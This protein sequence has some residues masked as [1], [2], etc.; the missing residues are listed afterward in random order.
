[1]TPPKFLL[2]RTRYHW[3]QFIT[4]VLGVILATTFMA[5]AP[6]LVDAVIELGLRR[7]LSDAGT[8]AGSLYLTTRQT[9]ESEQH[10]ALEE[11]LRLRLQTI[12]GSRITQ[13]IPSGRVGLMYPWRDGKLANARRIKLAFHGSSRDEIDQSANLI[14]GTWPSDTKPS[15]ESI[16]VVVGPSLAN[17]FDL[18]VGE[19][20]PISLNPRVAEPELWLEVRGIAVS[21]GPPDPYWFDTLTPVQQT[22][23]ESG[24]VNYDVFVTQDA[25]FQLVPELYP[26]LRAEYAWQLLLDLPNSKEISFWQATLA[27][28]EQDLVPVNNDLQ[29]NTA[30]DEL[31]DDF[32]AQAAA[33]R[34]PLYFLLATV[35]LIS[36][37]YLVMVSALS[38]DRGRRE[39][40]VMRS[41][42][43]SGGQLFRLQLLEATLVSGIALISGPFLAR[44]FVTALAASGPLADLSGY[45]WTLALSQAAWL[46]AIVA[47]LA[48]VSSLLLPLPASLKRSIVTHHQTMSRPN[49]PPWWQR[50]YLDVFVLVVG[51][52]LLWR[53]QLYGSII[54]GAAEMPRVD[55]L[56]L[57]A[58]LSLLIGAA[59]L[60]L[61]VFPVLLQ[62]G[63]QLASRGRGL[64]APLALWQAARDP[65]HFTRLVLLLM[66][67]MTLG[68]FSTSLDAAL[69]QNERDR[70]RYFV[71][72]DARIVAVGVDESV[73]DQADLTGTTA[74]TWRTSASLDY[75][76][77]FPDL[78]L[79]AI[80]PQSFNEVATYRPD[81]ADRP[82]D[83]LI[84]E[85]ER[86]WRENQGIRL[87]APLPGNLERIGLWLSLPST[88]RQD[89]DRSVL[90]NDITIEARLGPYFGE[91][92]M[93]PLRFKD[94]VIDPGG[95]WH[96][97]E[98]DI[99]SLSQESYPLY[100]HALWV[101]SAT[102]NPAMRENL[103][104]DDIAVIDETGGGGVTIIEDFEDA[105]HAFWYS[106]TA[107][108]SAAPVPSSPRSGSHS[109]VLS[110]GRLGMSPVRSYGINRVIH[111]P[112]LPIPALVS[113]AFQARTELQPGS[114]FQ[115]SVQVSGAS[116]WVKLNFRIVDEVA[117]F[118]TMFD[119]E[120]AGYLVTLIDPLLQQINLNRYDPIRGNE[121]LIATDAMATESSLS[122]ALE[123]PA[124]SRVL[125]AD[126]L[127]RSLKSHPLA[128]GLRSATL[129]GSL[130]TTVLSL[131]GF[132]S[133]FYMTARQRATNYGILRAIGLS[134]RQLYIALMLEQLVLILS[135]LALG[136]VLGL[137][138]NEL[139]LSGLP[140]AL[141]EG[142]IA[143]PF[144]PQ[145]DWSAV[146][147]VYLTLG[148][149]FFLSL[150][151][152]TVFL[153]RLQIHHVLR[154]GE[155]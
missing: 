41:R 43:A 92:K 1:V 115:A 36:L 101:R 15:Q 114:R 146:L 22:Q 26:S 108:M 150:G 65:R 34:S 136:T 99:P 87:A 21:E 64:S 86:F 10:Q 12:L 11:Q 121:L 100:L 48:S 31:F 135:G 35:V 149:T 85:M 25:F 27:T 18:E 38:L 62:A 131:V 94:G 33:V 23:Q 93:V 98:A 72:S 97:F 53:L 68:L 143:P 73:T 126:A 89:P 17:D 57:L 119:T 137:L 14:A 155:E 71:G 138:L 147:R 144:I 20:L 140:L 153:W 151:L 9:P 61:R 112:H 42:G 118:P 105:G 152:A 37:Y 80:D 154:V 70:S 117:F 32:A 139:T 63:A 104:I 134:S 74:V 44:I 7:T 30:L 142:E 67:A 79:L 102:F 60:L 3:Q 133:H 145:T 128:L 103:W 28:L 40:A 148:L 52:I 123:L 39:F 4:L 90:L 141:G 96:Y 59:A 77:T 76:T 78:S 13:V 8:A 75:G 54:G 106:V 127:Y 116:D 81:F 107:P 83:D 109:L 88:R 111:Q 122:A 124:T 51:L 110:F 125:S 95:L 113:P 120:E 6:L 49:I 66:L 5:A 91:S 132:S 29:V 24:T 84:D 45:G 130:L 50:F 46:A 2:R 47:A 19:R 58:P 82:L 56:L 16:A 55:F 129:F 69:D